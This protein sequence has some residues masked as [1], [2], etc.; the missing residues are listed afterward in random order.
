MIWLKS[1]L[2][3][4][5]EHRPQIVSKGHQ[6]FCVI[7]VPIRI[8]PVAPRCFKAT[9]IAA[10]MKRVR[11]QV[12]EPWVHKWRWAVEL[13]RALWVL[14][15]L[16]HSIWDILGWCLYLGWSWGVVASKFAILSLQ[17]LARKP[18]LLRT[19]KLAD[20]L[21]N[22]GWMILVTFGNKLTS[23]LYLGWKLGS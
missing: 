19:T 20:S 14:L 18:D 16:N 4:F 8:Q 1:H 22:L 17:S 3:C 11:N 21:P 5:P 9:S 23:Q 6:R 13:S 7:I 15:F 10:V 2:C 12:K